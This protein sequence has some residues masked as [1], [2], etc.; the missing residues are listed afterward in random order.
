M[1]EHSCNVLAQIVWNGFDLWPVAWNF[2][3]VLVQPLVVPLLTLFIV[4]AIDFQIL[5]SLGSR[6]KCHV[7]NLTRLIGYKYNVALFLA[8]P[9]VEYQSAKAFLTFAWVATDSA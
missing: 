5:F 2:V 7:L 4:L 3:V 9:H 8:I 6:E 1:A